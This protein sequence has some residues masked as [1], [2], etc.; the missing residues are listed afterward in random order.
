MNIFFNERK[1]KKYDCVSFDVFDTLIYRDTI[2][3]KTLYDFIEKQ[4]NFVPKDF[5]AKRKE[6]EK[7]ARQ[8]VDKN[9]INLDDI[10]SY[11]D[12]DKSNKE[13]LMSLEKEYE[14]KFCS[15]K[16]KGKKIFE[17]AQ[18]LNKKIIIISD[19][20]FDKE[21]I[22]KMLNKCGYF[23]YDDIFVSS[24]YNSTKSRVSLYKKV[25]LKTGIKRSKIIHIGDNYKSDFL[26]S[27]LAGIKSIHLKDKDYFSVVFNKNQILHSHLVNEYRDNF[28][29]EFGY[30]CLGPVLYGFSNWLKDKI[31]EKNIKKVFFLSREGNIMK[32]AFDLVEKKINSQYI[33]VSRK[34]LALACLINAN[35]YDDIYAKLSLR[36]EETIEGFLDSINLLDEYFLNILDEYNIAKENKIKKCDIFIDLINKNINYIRQRAIEYNSIVI[37]YLKQNGLNDKFA[38]VDIGWSGTMQNMICEILDNNGVDYHI[39]GFYFGVRQKATTSITSKSKKTGYLYDISNNSLESSMRGFNGLLEQVFSAFHGTTKGYNIQNGFVKPIIDELEL[40][41]TM[42]ENVKNIQENALSFVINFNENQYYKLCDF[43]IDDL[44]INFYKVGTMPTLKQIKEFNSF[45]GKNIE[46]SKLIQAKPIFYYL[47]NCRKFKSDLLNSGWK[48]GFLKKCF[49]IRLPYLKIFKKLQKR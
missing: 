4:N 44:F 30:C 23:G 14:I 18:K 48:I 15:A 16:K 47:F 41:D 3:S 35:T 31:Y 20:Y 42:L 37:K 10:Y 5:S 36:K 13:L 11:I 39:E 24:E 27:R 19:M 46:I 40:N 21:Q 25:L 6:A 43:E 32:K 12:I 17:L 8:K 22:E 28:M 45:E 9:E 49:K 29:D 33:F 34:S 26:C 7:I 1:I 38:L 2:D